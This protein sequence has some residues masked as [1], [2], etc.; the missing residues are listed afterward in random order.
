MTW[1][2]WQ[3]GTRAIGWALMTLALVACGPAPLTASGQPAADAAAAP[4]ASI[5]GPSPA[6]TG[7]RV[8]A[9]AASPTGPA[10]VPWTPD[11]A[12]QSPPLKVERIA[13]FV[14]TLAPWSG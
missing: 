6:S 9:P 11:R 14:G 12:A 3:S 13:A 10:L 1:R 8:A 2:Q 4:P 5:R 7:D